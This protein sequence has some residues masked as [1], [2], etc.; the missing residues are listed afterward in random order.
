MSSAKLFDLIKNQ[1]TKAGDQASE[2][3]VHQVDSNSQDDATTD[4]TEYDCVL[5]N[6]VP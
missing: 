6:K 3:Y 2:D 4:D 5:M 1:A